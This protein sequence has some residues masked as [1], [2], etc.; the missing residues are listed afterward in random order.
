MAHMLNAFCGALARVPFL[1]QEMLRDMLG[2]PT[3]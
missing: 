2:V 3:S 1:L